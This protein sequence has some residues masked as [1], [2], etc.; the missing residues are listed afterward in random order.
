[1]QQCIRFSPN[2]V[3]NFFDGFY[4]FYST[5]DDL[6]KLGLGSLTQEEKRELAP[7]LDEI[8]SPRYSADDLVQLW[9]SSPADVWLTNGKQIRTL[10]KRAREMIGELDSRQ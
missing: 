6:A 10:F 9:K 2:S 4:E 8:T 5:L 1:M 3:E 7:I